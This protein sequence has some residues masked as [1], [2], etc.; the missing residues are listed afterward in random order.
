MKFRND[1][2]NIEI[3][4][5]KENENIYKRDLIST[6]N[7]K[8]DFESESESDDEENTTCVWFCKSKFGF[9][10]IKDF[11]IFKHKDNDLPIKIQ[12]KKTESYNKLIR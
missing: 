6:F 12:I 11:S 7:D 4:Q 3:L 8:D 2:N 9:K 1:Q 10:K 5:K